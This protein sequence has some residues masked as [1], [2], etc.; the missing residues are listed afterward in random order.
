VTEL[1]LVGISHRITPVALRE[2]VALTEREAARFVTAL[3][4]E[5]AV[6]EAV[7]ISTCNR[8]E[9]YVVLEDAG[10]AAESRVLARL[11]AHAEIGADELAEVTYALRNCD[12]A[13]HLFRVTAGLESMIVGE[14]E[15]QGQVRRAHEAARET[16]TSGPLTNRL[17]AAALQTGGRVR[18]ETAIA[19]RH[20]SLSSVAVELAERL[21]GDLGGRPVVVIGA[22]E[23]SE[24]T[25]QALAARGVATTFIAN[26]HADRARS[27]AERFGGSVVGLDRLP[28]TLESAD[29]VLASTSSPH[30]IVGHEELELVMAARDRRPLLLIDIAVP[31]DIDPLCGQLEGVTLRDIDDL[32]AA[33]THNISSRA[34]DIPAAEEIIGEEI[35]RFAKWLGQLDVRPTIGALHERGERILE[36]VLE[37]NAGRW[38]SA[39]ARDLARVEALARAVVARLL[40]EPTIRLRSLDP[41]RVHGSIEMLRDLFGLRGDAATQVDEEGA[42]NRAAA[43]R[44]DAHDNVRELR[45]GKP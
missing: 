10:A 39:S 7:A 13:R 18:A 20:V 19:H 4:V 9:L 41:E 2:R 22:G 43:A 24:L 17:F 23:T 44:A 29:I 27:M 5:P 42:G 38:E 34:A 25:A 12:A 36:H 32:Q 45:S 16:G 30:P 26:R 21:L 1:L 33:V 8:T 40:H 35:Q 31:R 6:S 11:A 28:E 15:I 14:H 3:C 37:E